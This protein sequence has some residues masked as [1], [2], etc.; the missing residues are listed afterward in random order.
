MAMN[1]PAPA[2]TR[3]L[4]ALTDVEWLQSLSAIMRSPA[5]WQAALRK[6]E[7]PAVAKQLRQRFAEPR[8][9]A[10]TGLLRDLADYDRA[11]GLDGLVA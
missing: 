1:S 10:D 9:V 11:F 6:G 7:I 4:T 5:P 8:C 2:R 3:S